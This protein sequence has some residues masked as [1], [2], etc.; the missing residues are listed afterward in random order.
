MECSN[1]NDGVVFICLSH[2]KYAVINLKFD[3]RPI[4]VFN[5]NNPGKVN[6]PIGLQKSREGTTFWQI[7]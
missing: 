1:L 5:L 3:Y 2:G 6:F 7:K 4:L